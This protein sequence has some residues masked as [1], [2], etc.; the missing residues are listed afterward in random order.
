M[1]EMKGSHR[2]VRQAFGFPG[3]GSLF[4]NRVLRITWIREPG[5]LGHFP[6]FNDV[7]PRVRL[8]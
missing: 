2:V 8:R 3:D 4:S 7:T 5:G 1:Q 6:L